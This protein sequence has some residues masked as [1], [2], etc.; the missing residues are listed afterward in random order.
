MKQIIVKVQKNTDIEALINHGLK[1]GYKI[2]ERV[3]EIIKDRS[4]FNFL[5][6]GSQGDILPYL[7]V[8]G[9]KLMKNED[10]FKLTKQDI[11][12]FKG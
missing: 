5:C 3:R 6:F 2:E 12:N 11:K 4:S 7:G 1:I 8:N 9:Y 10:F